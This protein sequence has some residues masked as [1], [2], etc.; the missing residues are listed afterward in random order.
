MKLTALQT[1]TLRAIGRGEVQQK[2]FGH[3]AWRVVGASGPSVGRLV[4]LGLARWTAVIGG[5]AELTDK[6]R[7][8]LDRAGQA[9]A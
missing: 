6:G 7:V 5:S 2:N 9:D 1:E 8:A 4:S 3:G